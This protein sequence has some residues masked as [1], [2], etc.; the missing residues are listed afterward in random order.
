MLSLLSFLSLKVEPWNLWILSAATATSYFA[1]IYYAVTQL[2]KA[3]GK[4]KTSLE[5][6]KEQ[7]E[8]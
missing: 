4:A 7:D 3:F 1:L 5:Q 6:L 2:P 8:V